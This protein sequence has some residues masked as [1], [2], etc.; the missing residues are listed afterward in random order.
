MART[1]LCCPRSTISRQLTVSV[2]AM[3]GSIGPRRQLSARIFHG[4]HPGERRWSARHCEYRQCP[5]DGNRHGARRN[6]FCYRVRNLECANSV[7]YCSCSL[8]CISGASL[9][10]RENHDSC[11]LDSAIWG[12]H[13]SSIAN[14]NL[15]R[16][17]SH[18][19]CGA[20]RRIP[21][22][23]SIKSKYCREISSIWSCRMSVNSV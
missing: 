20:L 19:A 1:S 7:P 3:G 11:D 13:D 15:R 23:E 4:Q 6:H 8:I 17:A 16:I 10:R 14:Q 2:S 9:V 18:K 5:F 12:R 22:S 21:R